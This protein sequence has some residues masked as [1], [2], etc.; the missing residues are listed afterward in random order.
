MRD[1]F[2]Q[3]VKDLLARRAAFRCSNPQCR[4]PTSGPSQAP[5]GASNIGEAAHITAASPGGPRYDESLTA[6]ERQA[7]ENGIWLCRSCAKMEDDDP[8]T[9]PVELL[10]EWK[11]L[12]EARAGAN[13]RRPSSYRRMAA[14]EFLDELSVGERL[15]VKELETEFGCELELNARVRGGD[16]WIHFDALAV[17]GEELV[18]VELQECSDRGFALWRVEHLVRFVENVHFERFQS[19]I[20]FIAVLSTASPEKDREVKSDLNRILEAAPFETYLRMYRL[21]RLRAKYQT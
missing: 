14:G 11:A 8:I 3:S 18:G 4:Q 2:P 16:G 1:D 5:R 15:V 19:M 17:R 21:H 7:P 20:L 13:L 10:R 6:E 12:A 9:F